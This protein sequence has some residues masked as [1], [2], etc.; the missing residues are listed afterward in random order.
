VGREPNEA[1]EVLGKISEFDSLKVH[2]ERSNIVD[3]GEI[4]IATG[5]AG[6]GQV[7]AGDNQE[8]AHFRFTSAGVVTLIANSANVTTTNN[9]D[10]TLNIYDAGTGIVVENQLGSTLAIAI[11][12]KYY[13]P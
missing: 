4:P 13:A 10:T 1:F 9:N 7:L 6:W 5:V 3:T 8:W 2:R 11:D 12:I